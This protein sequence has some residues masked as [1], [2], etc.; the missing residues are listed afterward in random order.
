[1]L[2]YTGVV[3]IGYIPNG[4]LLGLSKAARCLRMYAGGL[5][6]QEELTRKVAKKMSE[7]T[8]SEDV[9][10]VI[11]ATHTCMTMRGIQA[12]GA[13]TTSSAMLGKFRDAPALRAEFMA[14]AGLS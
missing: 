5:T 11:T 1:M 13:S 9:A 2:P 6:I 3:A 7:L 8:G 12:T 14:L 4:K 10:V